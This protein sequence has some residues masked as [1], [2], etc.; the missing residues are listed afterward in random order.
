MAGE[1]KRCPPAACFAPTRWDPSTCSCGCP[2]Q[3]FGEQE[4]ACE[5]E[6][7]SQ[8][9]KGSCRCHP[10]RARVSGGRAVLQP[11]QVVERG[12]DAQ[13][14]YDPCTD[15]SRMHYSPRCPELQHPLKKLNFEQFRLHYRS[16]DIAGWVLLGSCIS[17]VIILAGTT[18]H[19]R[20]PKQ[21]KGKVSLIS[22][23]IG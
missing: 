21:Y 14:Q 17:L 12:V 6:R 4:A 10:R 23:N 20:S 7:H 16:L 9:D 15:L 8:W 13:Q 2:R 5:Q 1:R 22:T 19:Y 18:W 11:S 3:E